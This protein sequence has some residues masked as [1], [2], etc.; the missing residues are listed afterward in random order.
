MGYNLSM[1]DEAKPKAQQTYACRLPEEL[2]VRLDMLAAQLNASTPLVVVRRSDVWRRALEI[3]CEALEREL[4]GDG[5]A[6]K[7]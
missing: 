6:A 7:K 4:S 2:V 3:G 5:E 1:T